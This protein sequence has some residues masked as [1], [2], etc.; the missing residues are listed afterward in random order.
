MNYCD[1]IMNNRTWLFQ[2]KNVLQHILC[3]RVNSIKNLRNSYWFP[4][5]TSSSRYFQQTYGMISL[6]RRYLCYLT[7]WSRKIIKIFLVTSK[8]STQR[9][10]I[11][12]RIK[13]ESVY[14]SLTFKCLYL[15]SVTLFV[16]NQHI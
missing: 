2:V 15:I 1:E 12:N 11:H 7:A 3:F 9:H 13:I 8:Y 16:A 14:L 6:R 10:Q 5:A 4:V